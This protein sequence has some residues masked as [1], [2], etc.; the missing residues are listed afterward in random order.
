MVLSQVCIGY[1]PICNFSSL[2]YAV[3]NRFLKILVRKAG[4]FQQLLS[5]QNLFISNLSIKIM[6]LNTLY[7]YYFSIYGS[8]SH[9]N[10]MR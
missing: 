9:S 2:N 8:F 7:Y 6:G 5:F 3:K 10:R 1:L 4:F